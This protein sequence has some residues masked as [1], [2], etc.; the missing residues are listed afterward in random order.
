M[1]FSSFSMRSLATLHQPEDTS[2]G[3]LLLAEHRSFYT[4]INITGKDS[5][6]VPSEGRCRG[7]FATC[8]LRKRHRSAKDWKDLRGIS[9]LKYESLQYSDTKDIGSFS[10]P[11]KKKEFIFTLYMP[12]VRPKYGWTLTLSFNLHLV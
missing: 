9:K 2:E 5:S 8:R 1:V 3:S 6:G 7:F 4:F 12:K 11:E 10:F